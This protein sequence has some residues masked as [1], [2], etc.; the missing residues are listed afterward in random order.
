MTDV[1]EFIDN[2]LEHAFYDPR[3][4]H[5]YYMRT[6]KLVGQNAKSAK[7]AVGKAYVD[8]VNRVAFGKGGRQELEKLTRDVQASTS[9]LLNQA[10]KLN[11]G[12]S[13]GTTNRAQRIELQRE[14]LDRAR[15]MA[16]NLHPSKRNAI[17]KKLDAI[18][19]KLNQAR[20]GKKNL[21]KN[22][23][24]IK[25]IKAPKNPFH[26]M[27][28]EK[29]STHNRRVKSSTSGKAGNTANS[30]GGITR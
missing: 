12:T 11:Q 5:E 20:R 18:D 16:K 13:I 15:T 1:D 28:I 6:R 4:A 3:K 14:K 2:F 25:T 19:R 21:E 17:E 30:R 26:N 23:K 24:S 27:R 9:D 8:S 29:T 10:R 22:V 7:K